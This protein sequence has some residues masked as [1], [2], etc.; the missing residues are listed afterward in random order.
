MDNS[1]VYKKMYLKPKM[2]FTK[3]LHRIKSAHKLVPAN[4][5][6][7]L[8]ASCVHLCSQHLTLLIPGWE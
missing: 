1:D 3:S 6:W 2:N 5:S 8:F 4:P 7:S